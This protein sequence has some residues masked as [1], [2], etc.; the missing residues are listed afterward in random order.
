MIEKT[1]PA[2]DT[3]LNDVLS[4]AEEELRKAGCP[5]KAVMPI[6]VALEEIFKATPHNTTPTKEN[7]LGAEQGQGCTPKMFA[8]TN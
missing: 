4:F 1:F 6:T 5:G 8:E 7:I 2:K 3:A